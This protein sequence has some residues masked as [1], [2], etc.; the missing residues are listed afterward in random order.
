M[1]RCAFWRDVGGAYPVRAGWETWLLYVAAEKGFRVKLFDNL[2]FE[3]ER[4]RGTGHQFVYW[5]AAMGALGYHPLYAMGRIA[6]NAMRPSLA[7]KR[8]LNMFRGYL[9]AKLGSSDD[10]IE[11]Y[12]LPLRSFIKLKQSERISRV[13]TSRLGIS[14]ASF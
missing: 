9:Q 10:F 6:V 1:V 14:Y 7:P 8:A 11:E 3:H 13:I 5:G 4:P 12:D 2:T